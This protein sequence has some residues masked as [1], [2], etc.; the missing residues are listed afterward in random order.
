MF[1]RFITFPFTH[2]D[3]LN[4]GVLVFVCKSYL[5]ALFWFLSPGLSCASV[6]S[7]CLHSLS[8]HDVNPL[9]LHCRFSAVKWL[10]YMH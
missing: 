2:M 9:F 8:G 5:G 7:K 6:D 4:I 1:S 3:V 10:I